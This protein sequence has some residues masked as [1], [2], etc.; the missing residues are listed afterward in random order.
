MKG[1]DENATIIVV[2]IEINAFR[3]ISYSDEKNKLKK[4]NI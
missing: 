4:V 3:R 1:H 2:I